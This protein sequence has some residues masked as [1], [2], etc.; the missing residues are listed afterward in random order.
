MRRLKSVRFLVWLAGLMLLAPGVRAEGIKI[1]VVNFQKALNLVDQGQKAKAQLKLDF[2]Q[3][4]KKLNLQQD[5]LKKIRDDFEKQRTALS[6]QA[7]RDQEKKFNDKLMELQQNAGAFRQDLATQEA[8]MTAS[9]LK[10]LKE[11]VAEIAK[12]GKFNLVVEG[13]QDAV[14]YAESE[15]DLTDQVIQLYNKRFTGSLKLN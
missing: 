4:Q 8:K 1:G 6:E 10:N 2:D 5:E 13:S 11:V 7:A 12:Q 3:K 15:S 14:L 9:I